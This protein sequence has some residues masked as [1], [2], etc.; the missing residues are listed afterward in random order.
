[1]SRLFSLENPF[2]QFLSKVCDMLILNVVF[3]FSCVPLFTIGASLSALNTIALKLVR[4]EEPYIVKGFFKAF[5]ANFK[6]STI[7][8]LLSVAVFLFFRYD[9]IIAASVGGTM[10]RSDSAAAFDDYPCICSS[11]F[12]CIPDYLA[13]HLYDKA[14]CPKCVFD[15]YRPSSIYSHHVRL[16]CTDRIFTYCFYD[17]FWPCYRH[18][19]DLR[20]FR[21]CLHVLHFIQPHL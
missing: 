18:Q 19:H 16:L 1:M 8:W 2:M 13:L 11:V 9:Y 15:E 21:D 3:I 12:V 5:A 14:G 20:F 4:R 17:H 7:V 10:F 6:Q